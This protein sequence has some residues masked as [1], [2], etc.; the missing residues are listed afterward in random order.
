MRLIIDVTQLVGWQGKL[1]GIPRVMYELSS[2]F[3]ASDD[4]SVHFVGWDAGRQVFWELP[5]N[6]I[7]R[8]HE[9][10]ESSSVQAQRTG[11]DYLKAAYRRSPE[12][13]KKIARRVKGMLVSTADEDVADFVFESTDKLLVLWGDWN[14]ANYR[15]KLVS[16]VESHSVELHQVA[17]DMLPLVTPQYSSHSTDG[18][19]KYVNEVYPICKEIIAISQC[20]KRDVKAWLKMHKLR[21][22]EINVIRLGEDFQIATP[23][24]PDHEFFRKTRP[25]IICVG[26]VETRKNHTLLYYVYKLAGA[27]GISLPPVVIVGRRGWLTENIYDLI[28]TDPDTKD[29]FIFLHNASDE[30]LS[31]LYDHSLFSVYPSHYEGWGLPIAESIVHGVPC[32]CSN[33]TSMPEIAGDLVG[34]F[35][36]TSSDECLAAIVELLDD[37]KRAKMKKGLSRYQPTSWNDTYQH[38]EKIILGEAHE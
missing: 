38:V 32:V 35:T 25:Y 7:E 5:H 8:T 36:P 12:S 13:V 17:Y 37:K 29:Q 22:P 16:V 14:D 33:T 21:I 11:R 28:T 24:K 30:E 31:W 18:L 26:T 1:T 15:A 6:A 4:V 23:K 3:A 34:Y 27:R 19:T 10:D 9:K 20:T 2:R